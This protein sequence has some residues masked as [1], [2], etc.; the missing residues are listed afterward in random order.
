MIKM[1]NSIRN[2]IKAGALALA[3]TLALA[4]CD[5]KA[6]D[7]ISQVASANAD[8]LISSY[9]SRHELPSSPSLS[10]EYLTK[11]TWPNQKDV[12]GNHLEFDL[13]WFRVEN[14]DGIFDVLVRDNIHSD[15]SIAD[16]NDVNIM[17]EE[18][19]VFQ[20]RNPDRSNKWKEYH[21]N[22]GENHGL[23]VSHSP[24]LQSLKNKGE[25]IPLEGISPEVMAKITY[26]T[27]GLLSKKN[28]MV[29]DFNS[30]LDS[31]ALGI[32]RS[33]SESPLD[34]ITDYDP[35]GWL[36]RARTQN[37]VWEREVEIEGIHPEYGEF[38][39]N[40]FEYKQ[41]G[42]ID[43]ERTKGKMSVY[44]KKENNRYS[45]FFQNSPEARTLL[46]STFNSLDQD[47][48]RYIDDGEIFSYPIHNNFRR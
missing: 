39:I 9:N 11:E 35:T 46:E 3:T 26:L 18:I 30:R 23:F 12:Y 40:S 7:A 15:G 14:T 34:F 2:T 38:S 27:H 45:L 37:Q 48:V 47:G 42:L 41:S 44:L 22:N 4:G 36:G 1:R 29:N 21:D 32:L 24:R 13:A 8:S 16:G 28:E 43:P 19:E 25:P 31:T 10:V 5:S 20:P 17:P 33:L 6:T